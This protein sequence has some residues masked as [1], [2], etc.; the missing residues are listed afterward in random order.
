MRRITPILPGALVAVALQ[1]A[2]GFGYGL[3]IKGTGDG[4]AY[5]AGLAVIGITLVALFLFCTVL[6]VGIEVNQ[7]L[8]EQRQRLAADSERNPGMR[9]APA[10]T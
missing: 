7:T 1:V 6:L 10:M 8:G 9:A 2:I 5:Q 3:Y 4:S